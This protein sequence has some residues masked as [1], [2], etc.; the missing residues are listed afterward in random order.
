MHARG[1]TLRHRQHLAFAEED[2]SEL[3][4]GHPDPIP[5]FYPDAFYWL[6]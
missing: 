6:D 1:L 5:V 3:G 2:L 4:F